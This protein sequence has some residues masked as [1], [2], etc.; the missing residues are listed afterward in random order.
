[1]KKTKVIT[2]LF[3]LLMVFCFT[4]NTSY[5][6]DRGADNNERYMMKDGKMM[7]VKEGKTVAMEG[8][9]KLKNGKMCKRTGEYTRTDGKRDRLKEGQCIDLDGNVRDCAVVTKDKR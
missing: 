4:V 8:D 5:A 9:V 6:Q 3:A 7:H 2:G 1:M